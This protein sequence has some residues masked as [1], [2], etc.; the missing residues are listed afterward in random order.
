MQHEHEKPWQPLSPAEVAAVFQ[1]ASFPWWIAG[2][3]A[4]AHFVGRRFRAHGDIDVLALTRDSATLRRHLSEWDCWVADPPGRLRRW[5]VG[6]ALDT[7][8]HDV[9]C[10]HDPHAPWA[11]Q[12]MLDGCDGTDWLSR[13]CP[14]IRRPLRQLAQPRKQGPLFLAPEIQLFYK[15]KSPRA[16]DELDLEAALP[17]L[18]PEQRAWLAD[19]IEQAYGRENIWGRRLRSYGAAS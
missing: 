15:A 7:N 8:I 10:R 18:A 14:R 6:E 4:I 1:K 9:W 11:F 5:P 13:R 12:I 2:G 16:K 19:S 17:L 3:H